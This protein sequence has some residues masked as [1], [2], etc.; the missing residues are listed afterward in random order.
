MVQGRPYR[1]LQLPEWRLCSGVG[2][3]LLLGNSNRM[4]ADG[5][6]LHQAR[7]R[8]DT[9]KKFF[10]ERV[11]LHWNRLPRE[12]VKSPSLE[13]FKNHGDVTM[14]DMVSG[15]GGDGLMAGLDEPRDLSNRNDFMILWFRW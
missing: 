8:L 14:R 5:F 7:F 11:V 10:S 2:Q 9:G 3:P 6:M 12:V 1:S 4:R 15:H 13:V